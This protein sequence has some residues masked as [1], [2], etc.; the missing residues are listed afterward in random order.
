MS[1][2]SPPAI[3]RAWWQAVDQADFDAAIG[4]MAPD[5]AIDWPLSNELKANPWMWPQVNEHYPGRWSASVQSLVSDG[6]SVDT[7]TD[8]GDGSINVVGISF[9]TVQNGQITN[10]V[11]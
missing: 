10:L 6:E 1:T 11:K 3:A 2:L 4:L 5:A 9:S 7:V 8:I